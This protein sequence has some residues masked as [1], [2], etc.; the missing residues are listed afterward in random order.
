MYYAQPLAR[1]SA[2]WFEMNTSIF[3]GQLA[4]GEVSVDNETELCE[5]LCVS[6]NQNSH[7]HAKFFTG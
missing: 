3:N 2:S 4:Y 5:D 6:S 1:H 7:F